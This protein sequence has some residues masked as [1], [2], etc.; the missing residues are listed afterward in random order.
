MDQ[1]ESIDVGASL[2]QI[3]AELQAELDRWRDSPKSKGG[4]PKGEAETSTPAAS[5]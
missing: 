4:H 5:A 2:A 1:E 3:P